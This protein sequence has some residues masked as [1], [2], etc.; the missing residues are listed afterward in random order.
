MK[1][2]NRRK[3][4]RL[5]E[6]D[7]NLV[8]EAAQLLE[9]SV[10]SFIVKHAVE[11]A[12]RVVDEYRTLRF[13]EPEARERFFAMLDAPYTPNEKLLSQARKAVRYINE[14]STND[15]ERE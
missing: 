9:V 3:E 2:K 11:A 5:T 8:Y 6:E 12:A 10:T 15:L 13:T 1:T 7:D 14:S 4:L